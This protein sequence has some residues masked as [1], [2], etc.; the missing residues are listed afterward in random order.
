MAPP[1]TGNAIALSPSRRTAGP[2][3]NSDPLINRLLVS[4]RSRRVAADD[5]VGRQRLDIAVRL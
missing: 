4:A 2:R 5:E 3:L 1:V